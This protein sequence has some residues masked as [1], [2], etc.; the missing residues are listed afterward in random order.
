MPSTYDQVVGYDAGGNPVTL[1]DNN[2]RTRPTT[3]MGTRQLVRIT[4]YTDADTATDYTAPNSLYTQLVRALQQQVELYA[5]YPPGEAF[6]TCFGEYAFAVDISWDTANALWNA[7]PGSVISDNQDPADWNWQF[8]MNIPNNTNL[9]IDLIGDALNAA[10]A[11]GDYW[12]TTGYHYADMVF[13]ID[14]TPEG[15]PPQL[16]G[17]APRAGREF[18]ANPGDTLEQRKAKR[19][20]WIASMRG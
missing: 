15:G 18:M 1:G 13:P 12:V 14:F 3:K 19:A 11:S 6:Y 4:V 8:Q 2:R 20:A 7:D 5:V 17:R 16:D 10:G 9:L